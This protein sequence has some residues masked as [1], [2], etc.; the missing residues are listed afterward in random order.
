MSD[1]PRKNNRRRRL[2]A[3]GGAV[4]AVGGVIAIVGGVGAVVVTHAQDR[5]AETPAQI[6]PADTAPTTSP[7]QPVAYAQLSA[8]D[9]A[10]QI[11]DQAAATSSTSA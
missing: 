1:E 8:Q 7:D 5:S 10:F 9:A 3:L 4:A 11:K 6:M 2:L